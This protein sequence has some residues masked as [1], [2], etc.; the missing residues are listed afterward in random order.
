[1]GWLAAII[2]SPLVA[3]ALST[4]QGAQ[5]KAPQALSDVEDPTIKSFKAR[6][7]A[8]VVI[9][10]NCG[11]GSYS[12]VNSPDGT[13]VSVLF[14]NFTAQGIQAVS[15]GVRTNCDVRI[16]L[17]LPAGYSLGVFRISYRGFAHLDAGQS[18]QLSVN[19]SGGRQGRGRSF[20]RAVNC[21]YD[22]DYAF[23]ENIGAGLMKRAGCGEDAALNFAATL[24]LL[25]NRGSREA[26]V[27]L[28]SLDGTARRGVV[29]YVDLKKC[30][31]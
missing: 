1:M 3:L 12:V 7:L 5:A 21:V 16:P 28:D 8:V 19:Y 27:T 24:D 30:R 6:G 18:A 4:S 26:L 13:A 9:Q 25:A 15:G 2:V 14:D 31:T 20:R 22:G 23:D 29:F 11:G 17:N 10:A